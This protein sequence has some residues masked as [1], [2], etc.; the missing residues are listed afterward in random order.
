MGKKDFAHE[1]FCFGEEFCGLDFGDERLKQRFVSVIEKFHEHPGSLIQRTQGT[2]AEMMSAYRLFDNSRVTTVEILR[3]HREQTLARMSLY[4]KVLALQDTTALNFSSHLAAQGLGSIAMGNFGNGQGIFLHTTLAVTLEGTPLGILNQSM[5]SRGILK[6]SDEL[7]ETERHR[8]HNGIKCAAQGGFTQVISVSDR[9]S[10]GSDYFALCKR[11][12]IEFVVR[13][14]EKLRISAN[15]SGQ[16][17][18]DVLR[19]IQSGATL[20]LRVRGFR[21]KGASKKHR[22]RYIRQARLRVHW[23]QVELMPQKAKNPPLSPV[24]SCEERKIWAV[25]V[26]EQNPPQ[27]YEPVSW[28][29]FTSLPVDGLKQAQE[30]V[31]IYKVRWEIETFHKLLKSACQVEGAQLAHAD[32]LK[33]LITMLSVVAW[34]LH[35]L[36]KAQRESPNLPCTEILE[37]VEWHALYM[38]INKTRKLPPKPPTLRQATLWI[39]KLGGFIGRKSDGE[40][41]PLTLYRGWQKL[42]HYI[43]MFQTMKDVYKR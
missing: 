3:A 9:E 25:L 14:K 15:H 13:A 21:L 35:V 28:L 31:D 5:W 26:E 34:R 27:A 7:Y 36:T 37:D 10:D 12:G 41:G 40:P 16:K 2:W 30:V 32:R 1:T 18:A 4:K 17:V 6:P 39:A 33:R 19:Q 8:W 24:P 42:I 11:E 22:P 38:A 43:E 20:R 23:G 29:L